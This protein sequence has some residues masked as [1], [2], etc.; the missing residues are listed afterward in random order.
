MTK[1]RQPFLLFLLSPIH[2]I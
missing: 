1:V 2:P